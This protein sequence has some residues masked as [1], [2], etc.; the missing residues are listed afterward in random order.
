ML[1]T[2]AQHQYMVSQ[3]LNIGTK[4]QQVTHPA[5]MP[6][7]KIPDRVLAK[8]VSLSCIVLDIERIRSADPRTG[9]FTYYGS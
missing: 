3:E 1:Y 4:L 7:T 6:P 2:E 8:A 5:D 9:S